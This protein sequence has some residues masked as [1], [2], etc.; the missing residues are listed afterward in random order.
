MLWQILHA[1]DLK[2]AAAIV[3]GEFTQ[4]PDFRMDLLLSTC[5]LFA[6]G[7]PLFTGF[8]S[9]H[10]AENVAFVPGQAACID[11]HSGTLRQPAIRLTKAP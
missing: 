11:G 4:C 3:F 1:T 7:V 9:G 6:P 8:P 5:R 10:G 2:R